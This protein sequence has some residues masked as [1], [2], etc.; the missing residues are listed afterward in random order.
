MLFPVLK[1]V[2]HIDAQDP[3]GE[4]LKVTILGIIKILFVYHIER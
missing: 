2:D 4:N 3:F 1:G